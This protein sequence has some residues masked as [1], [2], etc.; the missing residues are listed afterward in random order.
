MKLELDPSRPYQPLEI[1]NGRVAASVAPDGLMLSIS[2]YDPEHGI[3][4]L[5]ALPAFSE[6][7]RHDPT[8]VRAHRAALADPRRPGFGVD[9]DLPGAGWRVA[10]LGDAVPESTFDGPGLRIT[11]TTWAPPD[12]A[13]IAQVW[14]IRTERPLRWRRVVPRLG[15][16]DYTQ[17]TEGGPLPP[18]GPIARRWHL[19][20]FDTEQGE[21]PPGDHEL[22]LRVGFDPIRELPPFVVPELRG[23]TT[24]SR[25]GLAYARIVAL[26]TEAG[27]TCIL[28]DHE[29]LPLSWNRDAYF[30]ASLLRERGDV[31]T[32]REHLEW[33]F[34]VAERPGGLW[35]RAHLANGRVKD[36]A[37][38]LDQQ[39]Y[40]LLEAVESGGAATYRDLIGGVVRAI[41]ARRQGE[42]YPTDE[43]PADDPL[44]L[45]YH[46]SSHVLL[47]RTYDALARTGIPAPD[48]ERIRRATIQAFADTGRFAYATDGNGSFRHYHDANDVPTA[49]APAW[50]F[51]AADDERWVATTRFA[52][53]EANAGG[54]Y[55]GPLGGLGSIHTPHPWPLG[56]LQ[57][58]VVARANGDAAAERAVRVKL[59]RIET[60]NHLIPE[61]YD[62]MSGAVRSRHW[63]AW[64]LALRATLDG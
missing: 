38:Q 35:G 48:A 39:C 23:A 64:P 13:G 61:A 34:R 25:R 43:T 63:F 1:G 17:L 62:E 41:E 60:W 28:A 33:L 36:R 20:G 58:I 45:P 22:I 16:A 18:A 51:C 42:L 29:I 55:P 54:F 6:A 8:A 50:G 59:D 57:A 49:F 27:A 3:V 9:L 4:V 31:G 37:F 7:G 14:R 53:S 5:T 44:G 2:T 10:L 46:F 56:D 15:R 26:R 19:A 40:P 12:Q 30:V 24:A 21:L 47:W 32:V 52:W 11:V